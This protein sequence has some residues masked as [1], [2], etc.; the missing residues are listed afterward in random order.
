MA[1]GKWKNFV[2]INSAFLERA[3][4]SEWG[5]PYIAVMSWPQTQRNDDEPWE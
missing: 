4:E 3:K 1:D 2:I 5:F